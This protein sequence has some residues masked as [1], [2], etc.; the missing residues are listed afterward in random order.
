MDIKNYFFLIVLHI[1]CISALSQVSSNTTSPSKKTVYL[2]PDGRV[3]EI[4]KLDSLNNAWGQG[5][6]ALSHSK[7]D[8]AKGIVHLVRI[9]DEMLRK[10]KDINDSIQ[11][12]MI[13]K[14]AP[15][16]EL[17]DLR[18]K[19]WSLKKLRGKIVV[20]NF[21]FTTCTPCIREMPELNELVR[22]YDSSNVVF[23]GLT[24]NN[25]KQVSTFLKERN[26]SYTLLPG[27]QEIDK[28]Y[29]VSSWP[30]SIVIDRNGIMKMMIHSDPKIREKLEAVINSIQ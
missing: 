11:A 19:Q 14:P 12:A 21:W 16:F 23:L 22:K 30:T 27:S 3:F 28:K 7:E 1:S 6:V 29:Q 4:D 2:L 18:G 20:L 10:G 17:A 15:G 25:A 26:F 13:N 5:R 24:F 8:D 9:T